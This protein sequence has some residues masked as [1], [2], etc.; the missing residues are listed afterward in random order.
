MSIEDT[1]QASAASAAERGGTRVSLQDIKDQIDLESYT[2]ADRLV[3]DRE[4][5]LSQ[6]EKLSV[7]TVCTLVMKNGWIVLGKSAPADPKSFNPELGQKLAYEDCIRQL[8]PVIGY[9][10][11]QTLYEVELDEAM[12]QPHRGHMPEESP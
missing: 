11:R 2:T 1:E 7:M 8:W 3:A 5:K 12:G 6:V 10:L 9:H 4:V